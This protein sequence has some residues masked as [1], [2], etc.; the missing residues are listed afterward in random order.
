MQRGYSTFRL[1]QRD[2][3]V[4]APGSSR[5]YSEPFERRPRFSRM[6][7]LLATLLTV[8]IASE[9][10]ILAENESARELAIADDFQKMNVGHVGSD[11][12]VVLC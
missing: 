12:E 7:I 8:T 1:L 4:R 11:P 10:K 5:S 6:A 9:P 3:L 2:S